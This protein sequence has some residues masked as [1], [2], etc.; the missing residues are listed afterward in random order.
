MK[1]EPLKGYW[2]YR[3]NHA[4]LMRYG[5][6]LQYRKYASPDAV[7]LWEDVRSAVEWYRR[8]GQCNCNIKYT[9]VRCQLINQA[10]EDVVND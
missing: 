5:D 7:E 6:S 10:F 1:P 2:E 9:C 8:Q 3:G 4:L